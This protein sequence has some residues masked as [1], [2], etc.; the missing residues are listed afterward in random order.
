[1]TSQPRLMA[2]SVA[3]RITPLRPGAS[4]PPVLI[5][6]RFMREPL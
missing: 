5:A 3:A 6:M 2:L 1:M 4:P